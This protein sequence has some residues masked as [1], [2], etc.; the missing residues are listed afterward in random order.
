MSDEQQAKLFQA[1]S[2]ADTSTTRQ[3]RGTGLGL[4]ISKRLVNI[5]VPFAGKADG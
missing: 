4:T 1:F 5:A 3:Y 2:Q